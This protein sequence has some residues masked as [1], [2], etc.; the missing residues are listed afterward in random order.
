MNFLNPLLLL[1]A[2]GIALPI[3]AHLLNKHQFQQTTWAAMQFLNRAVNVRSRQIK[4]RDFLLLLLRCAV[5]LLLVFAISKPTLEKS[6]AGIASKIGERRAGVV[7]AL[8]ASFSMQHSDGSTTRFERALVKVELITKTIQPGDPVSLILLGTEHRVLVHNMAYDA[9]RFNKILQAQKPSDEPLNLDSVPSRLKQLVESMDAAQK[10]IHIITDAQQ[11]DWN[12]GSGRIP[13]A[14]NEISQNAA[15]VFV[16]IEGGTDNLAIT[17]L[18]LVSGVLR[19]GTTARYRATV[20]NFGDIPVTNVIVRA[21]AN[22]INADTKSIPSIAAGSSE[23]VS[24]FIPFQNPGAVQIK[25]ELDDDALPLDNARRTVA[26]IRDRV[27]ILCVEATSGG[28]R[29]FGGFIASALRARDSSTSQ[30]DFTVK[31]VP[32]VSLPTIDLKN[33][34]VVILADVPAITPGQA[35]QFEDYVRAGNGLVWFPGDNMKPAIWNKQ[36]ANLLPAMIEQTVDTGNDLGV[37]RPLDPAISDHSV[38]RPLKSL[39]EDLLSETQFLKVLKVK[40]SPGSSTVLALAGSSAP[41]LIERAIGR[42]QVFMFTSSAQPTWNNMAL[43]PV[44][45]MLIQQMVTYLTA[46]E[47]EKPRMV[48][49]S[50]SLSYVD[51]PDASDAVFDTPAGETITVP[52]R[53]YRNQYVALLDRADEAGFYLARV[54]VQA[55]SMPIA[56]NVDTSESDVTCLSA[57]DFASQFRDTKVMVARSE[58]ELLD[59]IQQSRSGLSFWR[60]LMIAGLVIFVL[61]SLLAHRTSHRAPHLKSKSKSPKNKPASA[62]AQTAENS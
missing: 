59:S 38:C 35:R 16:P 6:D 37:G 24:L 52:V 51:Q 5:I 48:G 55:P 45:P 22:N 9:E 23:T 28:T 47:F 34:D 12:D 31:S 14:F 61:E 20:R 19:K 2:L 41:L 8:D 7:I 43:T 49:N 3:L 27:S 60:S 42:G 39:S 1:G 25:A 21:E 17:D 32:W 29:Q 54:S 53:E 44:F 50:L 30:E 11:H 4:L 13:T 46:R 56:V 40:P 26:V 57:D 62:M 58:A 36:S 18:E 15:V 33:F 10:E